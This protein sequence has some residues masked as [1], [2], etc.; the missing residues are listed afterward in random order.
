MSGT[1]IQE[2]FAQQMK[3]LKVGLVCCLCSDAAQ[4]SEGAGSG[5]CV[6]LCFLNLLDGYSFFFFFKERVC[7]NVTRGE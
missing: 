4:P 3:K 2:K 7:V 1:R 6:L 5:D